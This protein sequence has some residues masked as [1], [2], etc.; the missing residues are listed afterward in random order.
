MF[1]ALFVNPWPFLVAGLAIGLFVPLFA[2]ATGKA[3][4]VSGGYAEAC[5]IG[6][7]AGPERW[8]LWFIL[9][10]PLGGLAAAL[11]GGGP[12]AATDVAMLAHL[13]VGSGAQLA[14]FAAGGTLIGFG[15]R[16]AGGCPSG[17]AILGMALCAKASFVATIGFMIGGFAATWALYALLGGLR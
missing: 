8:K 3:L 15:A 4:G 17:H 7:P 6:K 2:G 12:Q 16:T 1:D 11:F 13:G 10:L 9:G 5:D 14:L